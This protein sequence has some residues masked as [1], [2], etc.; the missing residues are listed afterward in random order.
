MSVNRLAVSL[1]IC[2]FFLELLKL[3]LVNFIDSFYLFIV[4]LGF[5]I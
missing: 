2:I 4:L 1:I 5:R 3:S